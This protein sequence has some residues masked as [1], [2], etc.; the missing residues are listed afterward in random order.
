[1]GVCDLHLFTS[2]L[3][4][5]TVNFLPSVKGGGRRFGMGRQNHRGSGGRESPIGIQG[6]SPVRGSGNEVPQELKNFKS[7]VTSKF[8]A[9]LAVFH[10][11]SP[12][13]AYMF[14]RACRH[15]STK[16][17]KWWGHLLPFP[18]LVYKWWGELPLWLAGSAAY[19]SAEVHA[20]LT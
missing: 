6:R 13:Y 10:A 3:T 8:Y 12:T 2:I 4:V 7:I 15:R 14:F 19:A 11:F 20:I 5:T 9:F 16:Y 1:V 17:A 18:P